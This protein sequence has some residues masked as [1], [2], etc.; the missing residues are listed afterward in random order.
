MLET[1][2]PEESIIYFPAWKLVIF[3]YIFCSD[4]IINIREQ[5]PLF[6]VSDTE[7]IA[8]KLDVKYP[9]HPR[10]N[11]STVITT[12]FIITIKDVNGIYYKTH[13]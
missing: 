5:Y 1:T 2:I 4:R 10:T 13:I 12:D 7:E 8:K 11:I 9:K 6:L 3:I